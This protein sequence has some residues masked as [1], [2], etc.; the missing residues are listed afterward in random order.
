MQHMQ[1]G[2]FD[3][4]IGLAVAVHVTLDN[5]R[6]VRGAGEI[7]SHEAQLACLVVEGMSNDEMESP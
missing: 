6:I 7:M 3:L 4:D 5:R 2:E 1:T